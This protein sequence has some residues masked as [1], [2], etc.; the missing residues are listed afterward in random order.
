MSDVHHRLMG[1]A[2]T[3]ACSVLGGAHIVRVHDVAA[4]KEVAMMTDAILNPKVEGT[5]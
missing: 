3:V 5:A 1:T 2:A 4:M